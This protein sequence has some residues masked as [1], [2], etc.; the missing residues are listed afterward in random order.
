MTLA[1]GQ[2]GMTYKILDIDTDDEELEH[3]LFTLGCYKDEVV[4]IV[5]ELS[6]SYVLAIKD[7]RYNV[8]KE[9]AQVIIVE[10]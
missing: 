5:S 6:A 10:E 7:G 2:V 4:S 8:D 3:F 9:L 1:Q